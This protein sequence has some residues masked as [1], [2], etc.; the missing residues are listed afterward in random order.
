MEVETQIDILGEVADLD[1]DFDGLVERCCEWLAICD[2]VE[3]DVFRYRT[4]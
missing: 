1:P 3:D 4:H 2:W